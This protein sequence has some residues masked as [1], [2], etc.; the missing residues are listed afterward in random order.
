VFEATVTDVDARG[1][2]LQL[3]DP[4]VLARL[5]GAA[6]GTLSLGTTTHVR[7]TRADPVARETAFVVA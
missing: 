7:L 1:A 5:D 4:A 3:Q 2:V 6:A